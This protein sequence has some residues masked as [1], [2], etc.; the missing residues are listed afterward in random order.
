MRGESAPF[1][2]LTECLSERSED[3]ALGKPMGA[4]GPAIVYNHVQTPLVGGWFGRGCCVVARPLF[5]VSHLTTNG[6]NP[7]KAISPDITPGT[8]WARMAM[9]SL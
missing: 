4:S 8:L 7:A 6:S 3:V 2:A 9:L 5:L 1:G